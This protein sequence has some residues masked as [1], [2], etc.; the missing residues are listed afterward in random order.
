MAWKELQGPWGPPRSSRSPRSEQSLLAD[1]SHA[2]SGWNL[3]PTEAYS[4]V[5]SKPLSC[6]GLSVLR[7]TSQV[8]GYLSVCLSVCLALPLRFP[9]SLRHSLAV[10]LRRQSCAAPARYLEGA[11]SVCQ[12]LPVYATQTPPACLSQSRHSLA[13]CF[14]SLRCAGPPA[15]VRF[16]GVLRLTEPSSARKLED[17]IS[18]CLP[19]YP[20]S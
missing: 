10:H 18:V 7:L 16:F 14:K 9:P 11:L 5:L 19:V 12:C 20:L 17:A 2:D 15:L 1:K 4:L 6:Q 3:I 13:A 8:S